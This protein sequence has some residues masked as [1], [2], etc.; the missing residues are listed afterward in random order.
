M[1]FV[2]AVF[3]KLIVLRADKYFIFCVIFVAVITDG[4][5]DNT[6]WNVKA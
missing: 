5:S 6:L 4:I 2:A 1:H 3:A